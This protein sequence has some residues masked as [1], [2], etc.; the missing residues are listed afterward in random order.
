MD[1]YLYFNSDQ[2]KEILKK[3]YDNLSKMYKCETQKW[4]EQLDKTIANLSQ[5]WKINKLTIFANSTLGIITH[6]Y[7]EIYKKDVF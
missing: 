6:G 5:K 4:F 3:V 1:I 2:E 7:S